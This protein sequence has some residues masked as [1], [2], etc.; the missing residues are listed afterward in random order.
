MMTGVHQARGEILLEGRPVQPIYFTQEVSDLSSSHVMAVETLLRFLDADGVVHHFTRIT[1]TP[2][3]L[4]LDPVLRPLF[5][6]AKMAAARALFRHGYKYVGF[7]IS[8]A[9]LADLDWVRDAEAMC[10]QVQREF[11]GH[12]VVF[13][14]LEHEQ[15]DGAAQEALDLAFDQLRA[16]GATFAIDDFGKL[17]SSVLRLCRLQPEYVKF[18]RSLVEVIAKSDFSHSMVKAIVAQCQQHGISVIAEGVETAAMSRL[19][20]GLNVTL[21][22]G[23][24]FD[25][26]RRRP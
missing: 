16:L 10:A 4:E 22:Q 5:S 23:Y 9:H 12:G 20:E 26:P 6:A 17:G 21:Q 24:H 7:N 1:D 14:I 3:A 15:P 25:R 2:E 11:P 18:D 19:W 8:L 13:E